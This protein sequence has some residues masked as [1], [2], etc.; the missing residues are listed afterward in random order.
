MRTGPRPN[1]LVSYQV[2]LSIL[3]LCLGHFEVGGDRTAKYLN[4][5]VGVSRNL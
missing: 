4:P 5:F 3:Q 1:I 2:M